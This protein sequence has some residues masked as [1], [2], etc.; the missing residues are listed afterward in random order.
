M[1]HKNKSNYSPLKKS[2]PFSKR[3]EPD[4]RNQ[5]FRRGRHRKPKEKFS[6][7]EADDRLRDYFLN[8]D[9]ACTPTHVRLSLLK[10]YFLL[11]EEQE[12][13]NFT[14][15]LKLRDIAIKHFIDSMMVARLTKLSF[16]LMDLGTGPGLPGIPLKILYPNEKIILAE[17]V[18]KRVE[19]LKNV[20]ERL[21][22]QELDIVGRN[23]NQDFHL[24]VQ[25]VITRAVEDIQNTLNNVSS[26]LVKGGR[27]F[28]MKGPQV[29]TE[30]EMAKPFLS[31]RYELEQD[32]SYT[33]PK[34]PHERRLLVYKK[35]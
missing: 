15:L 14:R 4:G 18:Q 10:F 28:F 19:F 21:G 17:G 7:E 8:H 11:M 16:P 22:L 33:L 31:D 9:F 34:T 23:I 30:I 24:P 26:C 25:G 29:D 6:F 3:T 32:I 20:R 27:V 12:H 2:A 5:S 35:L 13:S 1:A